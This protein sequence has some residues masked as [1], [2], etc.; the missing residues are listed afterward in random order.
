MG[1]GTEDSKE[2]DKRIAENFKG[3]D[4]DIIS[5][6][7]AVMRTDAANHLTLRAIEGLAPNGMAAMAMAAH[8]GCNTVFGSTPPNNPHPYP[9]MNS[10]FQDGATIGWLMGESFIRDHA[11]RSVIPER[12]TDMVLAGFVNEFSDNDYFRFS[13]FTDTYMSDDEVMELPKVW[14]VGGDG[15]MGDIGFQNVSKAV[16][17]NRPNVKMIMLDTQVYSNTGGQNSESSVMAGGFDMNQIGAATSGK[18]T[19][20]KWVA[21][22]FIGGHG[23][24]FVAQVS[25]AN[26]G[27]LYKAILDGLCYRGT[28]FYQ[29]FTTCQPEH[30]V[31]DY[32]SPQQALYVRDSRGVPEFIFNPQLGESFQ[33][34]LNIKGNPNY[35]GDW[36]RAIAPVSKVPYTYTPAHW[37]FTEARFRNHHKA[38]DET[39]V[40]GKIKLEDILKLITQDDIVHRRFLNPT[41]R[42]FIPELGVYTYEHKD[43]GTTKPHLLSRQM[44]LFC[45][46]RRKAWRMMQSRAGVSNEDY[47]AQKE[48]IQKI[49]IGELSREDFLF[50]KELKSLSNE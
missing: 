2:T 8:T 35:T 47:K 48:L 39:E 28:A 16:L 19:E 42:S 3:N 33:E 43:D 12:L 41:H 37:A 7:V 9:W 34:A 5:V 31:A 29:V 46:E 20:K 27:S 10:L 15:G 25:L 50:P 22:A 36:Y 14:V 40:E 21:E 30:G 11:V 17:Q 24:P 45:V 38:V 1:Y 23:S 44:V 32:A 13:H 49:D 26:S 18:L 4:A 6:L